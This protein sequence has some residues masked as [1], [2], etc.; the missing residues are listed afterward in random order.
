MYNN[1]HAPCRGLSPPKLVDLSERMLVNLHKALPVVTSIV[2]ILVVAVVRDRSRTAAAILATMPINMVLALWIVVGTPDATQGTLVTFIQSLLVGLVPSFIWLVVV[3]V[4]VRVG[5]TLTPAILAG[6]VV[7][8]GLT[9][10]AFS[11]GIF[12]TTR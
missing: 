4:A 11:M 2:I 10:L 5:W 7:W 9:A 1:V 6:Y 3:Y 12:T 8:G